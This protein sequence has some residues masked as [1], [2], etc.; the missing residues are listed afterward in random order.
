MPNPTGPLHVFANGDHT[1]AT[2]H[3]DFLNGWNSGILQNVINQCSGLGHGNTT[4]CPAL[5]VTNAQA[6]T[7]ILESEIPNEDVGLVNPI[8]MLPGCNRLGGGTDS[9]CNS[10]VSFVPPPNV[11]HL[12]EHA[13]GL[14]YASGTTYTST[15]P[16][17]IPFIASFRYVGCIFDH[18]DRVMN[19]TWSSSSSM[20][21]EVCAKTCENFKYF[22]LE[23]G[24]FSTPPKHKQFIS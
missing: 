6:L 7:C 13:A 15:L 5:T 8:T 18:S 4:K 16:A 10:A 22:G 11:A 1:A 23:D 17:V 21:L 20:T 12:Y 9:T 3:G 19:A 14:P 24:K 2:I